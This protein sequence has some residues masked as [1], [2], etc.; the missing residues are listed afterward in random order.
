[1]ETYMDQTVEMT[2]SYDRVTRELHFTI[3]PVRVEAFCEMY[4]DYLYSSNDG[5]DSIIEKLIPLFYGGESANAFFT[6]ITGISYKLIPG[7]VRRFVRE[8]RLREEKSGK[9]LWRVLY[10][11]GVYP[12]KYANWNKSTS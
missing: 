2:I 1:M 11:S 12:R 8:K 6:E 10:E 3:P 7:I 5:R 4:D 9:D